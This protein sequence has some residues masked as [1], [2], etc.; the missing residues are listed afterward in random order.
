MSDTILKKY[1]LEKDQC[2]INPNVRKLL[3]RD[4]LA[5]FITIKCSE[6]QIPFTFDTVPSR[7]LIK[8]FWYEL[9]GYYPGSC[10]VCG[11]P[12]KFGGLKPGWNK[13]CNARCQMQDPAQQQSRQEDAIQR[14][15]VPNY[16]LSNSGKWTPERREKISAGVAA[17]WASNGAEISKKMSATRAQNAKPSWSSRHVKKLK[18][19]EAQG[20]NIESTN[21]TGRPLLIR[22]HCGTVQP[23]GIWS[24]EQYLCS[25]CAPNPRIKKET[26]VL[27]ELETALGIEFQRN[28]RFG[29]Y[30]V[31]ALDGN[32]AIEFNGLFWHSAAA[33]ASGF[34]QY[35]PNYHANKFNYFKSIGLKLIQI[36]EDDWLQKQ[37]IVLERCR[38]AFGQGHRVGARKC[39]LEQIDQAC[40]KKFLQT[41][42]LAGSIPF[43]RALALLYADKII[44]VAVF[45]K[46]RFLKDG[47]IEL[48]R[49]CSNTAVQGGLSRLVR[50]ASRLYGTDIISY[51]DNLWGSGEGYAH[52]GFSHDATVPAGYSYYDKKNF[53]R[54]ARQAFRQDT[55]EKKFSVEWN[56]LL[57]EIENAARVGCFRIHDAGKQRWRYR[58]TDSTS[59]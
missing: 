49:F 25:A 53:K 42:H 9:H 32:V 31:D 43:G 7:E 14:F 41:H 38:H 15:G 8:L 33:E 40:A 2:K 34:G 23:Y 17:A 35:D 36:F 46:N 6:Y 50:A 30:R 24:G 26:A 52:A 51:S 27:N 48:L 20:F 12:T 5:D 55:F 37:A 22:H 1:L 45:G 10:H 4:G 57:N 28:V 54:I 19:L 44:A 29:P 47:S 11:A 3:L 16:M 59:D 39:K 56:P 58:H 13:F 21:F 18:M